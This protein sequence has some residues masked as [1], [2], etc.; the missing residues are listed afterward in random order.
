MNRYEEILVQPTIFASCCKCVLNPCQRKTYGRNLLPACSKKITR[1]AQLRSL[2]AG[3]KQAQSSLWTRQRISRSLSTQDKMK[4]VSF[5]PACKT[6]LE[7]LQR[8]ANNKLPSR[9]NAPAASSSK[10]F[11]CSQG[12][13]SGLA[14]CQQRAVDELLTCSSVLTESLPC[15]T[16]LQ[17]AH[18]LF[19]AYVNELS[20]SISIC[21]IYR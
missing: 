5:L 8:P 1:R 11:F 12:H 2:G 21:P 20:A 16:C 3:Q 4:N 18:S 19:L 9:Q 17:Q 10:L 7:A 14:A 6:S 15:L 13:R